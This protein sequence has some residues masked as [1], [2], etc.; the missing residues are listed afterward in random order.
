VLAIELPEAVDKLLGVIGINFPEVNEDHVRELGS[1]VREF[2]QNVGQVH[3]DATDTINRMGEAYQGASYEL[4][5]Q[6]W[7]EMSSQHMTEL[8]EACS[9]VGT[10]MD[11][12]ADFIVAQKVAAIA[13]LAVLAATFIAD[14]AAAAV[15]FGLSELALPAIELGA[16]KLCDY[17]EQQL[18][19]YVIGKVIEA[20]INPLADVVDKA[21][22]GFVFQAAQSALGAGGSGGSVGS[23]FMMRPDQLTTHARTMLD[24]AD[25][26]QQHADT[27]SSNV[28]ALT[29]T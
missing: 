28:S 9:V 26:M 1:H 11:V 10:A 22:S 14:Q 16:R 20:A 24:H 13:E 3:Q 4:L 27:F 18:T 12:A 8:Q 25:T 6:R 19:Q 23:S 17:L 5:V 29:F 15:T 2:A 7:G 21:V